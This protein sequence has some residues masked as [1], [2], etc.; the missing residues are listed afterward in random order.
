MGSYTEYI[1]RFGGNF[2]ALTTERKAQLRRISALRGRDVLVYAAD[3]N[4]RHP[5]IPTQIDYG[6]LLP[7]SDLLGDL[8]GTAVDVIIE[9]PGGAGEIAEHF[10]RLLRS[11]YS[12]VA[13]IV[14]GYAKSA[15]TIIV[16]SGDEILMSPS[17]ALGPI[18]AQL[19]WQGK[20]FSAEALLENFNKIKDEVEQT[21]KLNKAYIPILQNLSPGDLQH[22]KNALDFARTLVQ[23]WLTRYKFK[24]WVTHSSS[25]QD[26]AEDERNA[27]AKEVADQ[28]CAHNRWLTHG[29]SITIEDL[30]KMRLRIT[31]FT[32][33]GEVGDAIARYHV[34]LQMTL[35]TNIYKVIETVQAQI[36]RMANVGLAPTPADAAAA[37]SVVLTLRCA[38]CNAETEFQGNFEPGV[39]LKPGAKPFPASNKAKCHR[40]GN[41]LDLSQPRAQIEAQA[42]RRFVQ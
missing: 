15:G 23:D 13:F 8:K 37:K 3:L 27:R 21:G 20:V 32:K 41:V 25:G 9:T 16:M 28:L 1:D 10:V 17:S 34:L 39:P 12:D 14:P 36:Y 6:D 18:D 11:K 24:D 2:D 4:N 29:R 30:E 42:N 7:F 31:D 38:S 35:A 33:L 22:A 19:F 5:D 40:C 26:V